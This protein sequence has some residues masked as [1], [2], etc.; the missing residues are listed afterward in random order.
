LQSLINEKLLGRDYELFVNWKSNSMGTIRQKQVGEMIKRN[1]GVVL[2]HEGRYIYEDA[3]VTVT[4]VIMSADL[5][6]AKIY[7]SVYNTDNKQAVILNMLENLTRLRQSLNT[8]I[9]RHIR[10][11]PEIHFF[12]DDTLDEMYRLNTLFDRLEDEDQM[13]HEEE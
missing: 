9:R 13:G 3:F 6:I 12:L 1:F 7:L 11:M 2:Q 5:G 10:R 8:R 4:N